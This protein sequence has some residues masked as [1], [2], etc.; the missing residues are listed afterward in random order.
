MARTFNINLKGKWGSLVNPITR[1]RRNMR[2]GGG[3]GGGGGVD[4][5]LQPH[6]VFPI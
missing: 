1:Y 2:G 4:L 3:G 6:Q 5:S